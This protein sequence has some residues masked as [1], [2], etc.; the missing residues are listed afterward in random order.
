MYMWQSRVEIDYYSRCK[1]LRKCF[2]S[3]REIFLYSLVHLNPEVSLTLF[4]YCLTLYDSNSLKPEIKLRT[5]QK[6]HTQ[7]EWTAS[8]CEYLVENVRL[9]LTSYRMIPLGTA[10]NHSFSVRSKISSLDHISHTPSICSLLH[11]DRPVMLTISTRP[12]VCMSRKHND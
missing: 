7:V 5:R 10:P 1:L 6:L 12:I 8:T 11:R 9:L 3:Y 4:N 2:W